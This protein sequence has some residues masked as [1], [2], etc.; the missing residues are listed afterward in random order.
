MSQ[1]SGIW[2]GS[3]ELRH[4][5]TGLRIIVDVIPKEGMAGATY[6]NHAKRPFRVGASQAFLWH[7]TDS[8]P[9]TCFCV[10]TQLRPDQTRRDQTDDF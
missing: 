2:V 9:K 8:D 5:Q 10:T 3:C 6:K 4:A 7:D 1:Q